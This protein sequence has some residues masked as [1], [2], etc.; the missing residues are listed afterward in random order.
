MCIQTFGQPSSQTKYTHMYV[1]VNSGNAGTVAKAEL[2]KKSILKS[3]KQMFVNSIV[4]Y[5]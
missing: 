3:S 1:K 5:F 2:Y 4:V